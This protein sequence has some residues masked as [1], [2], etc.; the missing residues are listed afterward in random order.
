MTEFNLEDS[1]KQLEIAVKEFLDQADFAKD[2][3][4]VLGSSTSE[5]HGKTIGKDSS[6]EVGRMVIDV[7]LPALQA[8]GLHLAVQG[9]QHLN[10]ALLMERS[11]AEKRGYEEVLVVP[12][13]HAGGA[14]QVAA[15]ERFADSVEVEHILAAGGIDIGDTAI[16]QHVK[17]VQ[18]P[19]RTS[20]TEIGFAHITYLTSRPKLIGGERAQYVWKP[21]D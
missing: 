4:V 9:C 11:E 15:Y 10:R 19:L 16:G 6:I 20:V 14:T 18:I 1:R 21:I 5:I 3:L 8:R 7:I 12:A 17:F 13:I 2:A